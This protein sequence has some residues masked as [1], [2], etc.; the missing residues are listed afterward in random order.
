MV[1][2]RRS[3]L[4]PDGLTTYYIAPPNAKA[5]READWT[6]SKTYTKCLLEGIPTAAEMQDILTRRGVIGS[7]FDQRTSELTEELHFKIIALANTTDN[8]VKRDLAIDVA[9]AREKLF[10]WQ[11]RLNGPMNNTCEQISEDAKLESLISAMVI[12]SN[13]SNVWDSTDDYMNEQNQALARE[14]RFQIMV[15]F[16]GMDPD[17]LEKTPEA[18]ALRE[19][20][21]DLLRQAQEADKLKEALSIEEKVNDE[22]TVVSKSKKKAKTKTKTKTDDTEKAEE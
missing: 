9:E 10:L 4:G 14:A 1:E 5:I 22:T 8:D 3:F 20:E 16:Q 15:Y 17:F 6:Y 2:N 12:D 19:V 13:D 7:D 18:L 11:Q 21:D